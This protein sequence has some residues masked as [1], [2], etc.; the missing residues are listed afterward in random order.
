MQ[1][2]N[3]LLSNDRNV[4]MQAMKLLTSV[5]DVAAMKLIIERYEKETDPDVRK[6]YQDTFWFIKQRK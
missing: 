6:A 3:L 2:F 5:N 4:K 1:A